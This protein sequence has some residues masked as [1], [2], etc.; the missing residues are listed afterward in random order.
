MVATTA[1]GNLACARPLFASGFSVLAVPARPPGVRGLDSGSRARW[2]APR[3]HVW[4]GEA[5]GRVALETGVLARLDLATNNGAR[6]QQSSRDPLSCPHHRHRATSS[7]DL[8]FAATI[9]RLG[10]APRATRCI[11]FREVN[12]GM[13]E[14]GAPALSLRIHFIR[15]VLEPIATARSTHLDTSDILMMQ[16]AAESHVVHGPP[17]TANHFRRS[18]RQ[19]CR[20][21]PTTFASFLCMPLPWDLSEQPLLMLRPCV[22][23][24]HISDITRIEWQHFCDCCT[25]HRCRLGLRTCVCSSTK[26]CGAE[27]WSSWQTHGCSS[28]PCGHR[29]SL[30]T[31]YNSTAA[32]VIAAVV[33]GPRRNVY[34]SARGSCMDLLL[35]PCSCAART[36]GWCHVRQPPTSMHSPCLE[37]WYL[38]HGFCQYAPSLVR[39]AC[40]LL[41]SMWAGGAGMERLLCILTQQHHVDIVA[42]QEHWLLRAHCRVQC[43]R[44]ACDWNECLAPASIVVGALRV[45]RASA[46]SERELSCRQSTA[47]LTLAFG[48]RLHRVGCF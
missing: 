12:H 35:T 29:R 9:Q 16:G 28:N 27:A 5:C 23:H 7:T 30:R 37:V 32:V 20:C 19:R 18:T 14:P 2:H 42:F 17:L 6:H 45:A 3:R 43:A 40:S 21:C 33:F 10:G 48:P 11:S 36:P 15:A 8:V 31:S 13:I 46:R 24:G 34:E 22:C 26:A 39:R 4:R 44:K 25:K 38:L 41:P 1:Q 47:P